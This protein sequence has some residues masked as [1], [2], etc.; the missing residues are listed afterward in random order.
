MALVEMKRLRAVALQSRRRSLLRQLRREGC[1]EVKTAQESTDFGQENALERTTEE[2]TGAREYLTII[3]QAM[4]CLLYTSIVGRVETG[5]HLF[6]GVKITGHLD[7]QQKSGEAV[8]VVS[9]FRRL[10]KDLKIVESAPGPQGQ[11]E[12]LPIHRHAVRREEPVG[13][14]GEAGVRM[15]AGSAARRISGLTTCIS[16]SS[17]WEMVSRRVMTVSYTHLFLP[18]G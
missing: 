3:G 5:C 12:I 16:L 7:G 13:F 8:F 6:A 18:L 10:G 14:L 17:C 4:D 1:V 11:A 2:N 9:V 15:V